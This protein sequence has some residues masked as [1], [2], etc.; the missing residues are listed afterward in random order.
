APGLPGGAQPPAVSIAV[1]QEGKPVRRMRRSR[2]HRDVRNRTGDAVFR[3]DILREREDDGAAE[4]V[5]CRDLSALELVN[6]GRF[7]CWTAEPAAV[8]HHISRA[9]RADATD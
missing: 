3:P 8:D 9:K 7:H 2:A 1:E 4:V 5:P 6:Q